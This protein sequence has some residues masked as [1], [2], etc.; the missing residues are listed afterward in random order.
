MLNLD[1][2]CLFLLG[3]AERVVAASIAK[4]GA[5]SCGA[6][7]EMAVLLHRLSTSPNSSSVI[8]ESKQSLIVGHFLWIH[9]VEQYAGD[10][11]QMP[12]KVK[13]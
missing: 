8:K 1:M 3:G 12:G 7:G 10:K 2:L 11:M 5:L 13:I 9:T 6:G 4:E